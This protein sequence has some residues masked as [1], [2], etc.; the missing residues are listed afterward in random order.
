MICR[1]YQLIDNSIENEMVAPLERETLQGIYKFVP[2]TLRQDNPGA[3]RDFVIVSI[4]F[5]VYQK[6]FPFSS[7][8]MKFIQY[9]IVIPLPLDIGGVLSFT[10]VRPPIPPSFSFPSI[11]L[12]P[13]GQII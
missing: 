3:T 9:L 11:T 1:Y 12:V 2:P 5:R 13:L 6:P 10:H 8:F 4:I 7:I